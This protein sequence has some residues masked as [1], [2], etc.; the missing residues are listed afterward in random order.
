VAG[1]DRPTGG[2]GVTVRQRWVLRGWRQRRELAARLCLGRPGRLCLGQSA[3]II[4]GLIFHSQAL[5]YLEL[6]H[7]RKKVFLPPL[8]LSNASLRYRFSESIPDATF[9]PV[10][11]AF[12]C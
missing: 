7:V 4:C 12:F 5:F 11:I 6:A 10:Y 8:K 9:L 1:S 2:G 3:R